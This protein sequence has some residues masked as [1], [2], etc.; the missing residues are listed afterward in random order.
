VIRKNRSSGGGNNSFKVEIDPNNKISELQKTNNIATI[1]V[2]IPLNGTRNLFPFDHSIVHSLSTNLTFQTTDVFSGNRSFTLELDTLE[3]FDSPYKK[4]YTLEGEVLN[5]KPVDLLEQ[6]S[7]VYY[8]RTKLADPLPGES[9]EWTWNSFVY[10]EDGSDGW[11]QIH[12]P[13]YLKNEAEGLIRDTGAREFRFEETLTSVYINNF[14]SANPATNLNVS[15]KLNG[16]E[17]QLPF[18]TV[19]ER[20]PCRNNTINIIAFSKVTTVPYAAIDYGFSDPRTCGK[21]PQVIG[22]FTTSQL[23]IP[24]LGIAEY[25]NNIEAGDSV[26]HVLI[27]LQSIVDPK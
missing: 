20:V 25:I 2:N 7:L 4:Q 23:E 5:K 3:T 11:A 15:I 9:E 16:A 21:E 26:V 27:A 22:S 6:D 18:S 19:T 1:D 12:F 24:G 14:G 13:Q 10:I 8:W 17:Y